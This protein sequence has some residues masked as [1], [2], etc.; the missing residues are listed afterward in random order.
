MMMMMMMRRR[1][2]SRRSRSRGRSRSRRWVRVGR[3]KRIIGMME[4]L[5]GIE[6]MGGIKIIVARRRTTM[7][8]CTEP[9]NPGKV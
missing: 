6:V 7:M 2:R 1:R 3:R 8:I 4:V 5:H 9:S